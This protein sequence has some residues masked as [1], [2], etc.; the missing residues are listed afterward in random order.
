[1][2]GALSTVARALDF[3]SVQADF[4]RALTQADADPEDA[5]TAACSILESTCRCLLGEMGEPIPDRQDLAGLV[6]AVQAALDLTPGRA[7]LNADVRAVLSGL[8]TVT[9][10]IGALRTHG[11]DAHGRGRGI[12]RV[13]GRVAR[14]AIHGA[15]T[16]ALFFIESWQQIR[17]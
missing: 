10:A 12:A 9:G 15:S 2:A 14:L 4:D 5:I 1:M 7:D 3:D 6:R 13:D 17:T 11:G 8:T 16:V